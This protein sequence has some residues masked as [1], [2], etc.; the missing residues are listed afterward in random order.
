VTSAYLSDVLPLAWSGGLHNVFLEEYLMSIRVFPTI[1]L[2]GLL[3]LPLAHRTMA[4]SVAK[5]TT[6]PPTVTAT[7]PVTAPPPVATTQPVATQPVAPAPAQESH[8]P[9]YWSGWCAGQKVALEQATL[10]LQT[11]RDMVIK[12]LAADAAKAEAGT[13]T[14]HEA[15]ERFLLVLAPPPPADAV[16]TPVFSVELAGTLEILCP[17]GEVLT[18]PAP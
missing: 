9:A 2:L 3:L 12:S 13:A 18:P 6:P 15:F 16:G 8:E 5:E 7:Q 17:T 11:I 14:L 4:A 1:T 10:A